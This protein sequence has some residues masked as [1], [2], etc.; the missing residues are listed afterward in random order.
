MLATWEN[1]C[2]T[3]FML[4]TEKKKR[5]KKKNPQSNGWKFFAFIKNLKPFIIPMHVTWGT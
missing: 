4:A 3:H 2:H 5:K 1:A